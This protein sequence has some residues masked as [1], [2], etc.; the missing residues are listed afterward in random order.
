MRPS[1]WGGKDNN[2][3]ILFGILLV[4]PWTCPTSL[5]LPSEVASAIGKGAPALSLAVLGEGVEMAVQC[6]FPER[7]R[8]E[9]QKEGVGFLSSVRDGEEYQVNISL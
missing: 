3:G 1:L 9:L 4:E 2:K 7:K 5:D 6:L 8:D